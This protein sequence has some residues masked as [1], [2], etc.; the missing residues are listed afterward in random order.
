MAEVPSVVV[1]PEWA[2]LALN[3]FC[4]FRMAGSLLKDLMDHSIPNL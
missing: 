2:W 1:N 4:L 3:D